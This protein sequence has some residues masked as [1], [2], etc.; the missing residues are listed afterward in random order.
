MLATSESTV[1]LRWVLPFLRVTGGSPSDITLL[2]REGIAPQDFADPDTRV[3][4]RVIM[5][6]L[7]SAVQRLGDPLLGLRAGERIEPGDFATLEFACRSS[8]N[9]RESILCANRY[10]HLMHGAQEAEL[11]EYGNLAAWELRVTDD[12]E[13]LPAANDFA[14]ATACWL[15]RRHTGERDVLREVH[16]RHEHATSES[17]YARVF[18]N[19]TIKLGMPHNALVFV[20]SHLDAPLALAHPGLKLAFELHAN[21]LLQRLRREESLGGRVRRVILERL[22]AREVDM[23]A[24]ARTMAMSV[25][26]LRRRLSEEGTSHSVI[27]DEVRRELAQRY[28]VEQKLAIS[29]VAFLLGFRHVAAFYKAFKRWS[30]GDTPAEFR[31]ES[32]RR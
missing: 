11:I 13:Q 5:E 30:L 24:I 31:S 4:H 25:A 28:L 15:A 18:D 16:F 17:E 14:L 6:L 27:L 22:A 3:R 2:A 20:R 7:G 1:S 8:E 12:V 19:A 32:Q 29:E 26:T 23:P 9:L 21:E 10:M